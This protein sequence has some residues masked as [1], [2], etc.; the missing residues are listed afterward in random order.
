MGPAETALEQAKAPVRDKLCMSWQHQ[1]AHDVAVHA[2]LNP[3]QPAVL[4]PTCTVVTVE[5]DELLPQ[6]M[7]HEEV[8]HLAYHGIA[9]FPA[10]DC[11]AD[12]K[13]DVPQQ[14]L[15]VNSKDSMLALHQ[16]VQWTWLCSSLTVRLSLR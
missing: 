4:V 2:H 13:V 11:L 15:T 1:V 14:P 6:T 5:M 7:F 12:Q 3:P 8:V 10:A 16:E 9:P